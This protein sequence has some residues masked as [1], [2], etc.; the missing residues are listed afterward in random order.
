MHRLKNDN[1]PNIFTELIRK[2][3]HKYATKFSKNSYTS[4]SFSLSNMKYCISVRG[5][6][7][8]NEYLQSKEKGNPILLTFSK[9]CK[10]KVN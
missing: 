9:N 4:K 7:L 1:V 3:K 6:N 5:P 8:W 2:S 10:I